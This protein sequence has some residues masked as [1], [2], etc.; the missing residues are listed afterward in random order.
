MKVEAEI[1]DLSPEQLAECFW[2]L[3]HREQARFFE[4]LGC[5]ALGTTTPFGGQ[6]GSYFGLDMQMCY[7]ASEASGNALRVMECIGQQVEPSRMQPYLVG[8]QTM[9]VIKGKQTE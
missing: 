4:R 3:D 6:V 9:P 2:Q 7:T 8:N 1:K 5:C